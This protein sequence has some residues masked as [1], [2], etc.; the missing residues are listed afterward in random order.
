MILPTNLTF[1]STQMSKKL[2]LRLLH[3]AVFCFLLALIGYVVSIQMNAAETVEEDQLLAIAVQVLAPPQVIVPSRGGNRSPYL[4]LTLRGQQQEEFFGLIRG[5]DF[6]K[7]EEQKKVLTALQA[8]DHLVVFVMPRALGQSMRRVWKIQTAQNEKELLD[9]GSSRYAES[10]V[11]DYKQG[12]ANM[13]IFFYTCLGISLFG[14][15][16]LRKLRVPR[17]A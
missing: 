11:A 1:T 14:I 12:S 3:V 15:L 8:N 2:G 6:L 17:S 9:L 5:W 13:M 7:N 4:Q 16:L 10:M